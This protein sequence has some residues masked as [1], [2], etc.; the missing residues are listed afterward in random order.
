MIQ[1]YQKRRGLIDW[2]LQRASAV[3]LGVYVLLW[4]VFYV[5]HPAMQY[6]DVSAFLGQSW[7]P[8]MNILVVLSV[9]LHAWVGFWTILT[10][11]VPHEKIRQLLILALIA[12]LG[13]YFMLA[14]FWL[15]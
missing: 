10:D 3:V 7:M 6:S 5:Q 12:G 8:I 1:F 13:G 4:T 9:L 14:L 15:L 11:Y 2:V